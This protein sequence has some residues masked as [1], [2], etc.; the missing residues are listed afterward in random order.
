M[1]T[2]WKERDVRE[3]DE[4]AKEIGQRERDREKECRRGR[5][6]SCAVW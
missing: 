4:R 1:K 5:S 3:R 6:G 2:G